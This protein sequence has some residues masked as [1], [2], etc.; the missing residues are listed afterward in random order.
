M[1]KHNKMILLTE[2]VPTLT[3]VG[4][5]RLNSIKKGG[6]EDEPDWE[7]LGIPNPNA[8]EQDKE[9]FVEL[10]EEDFEVELKD[11]IVDSEYIAY[12]TDTGEDSGSRIVLKSG[13]EIIVK[14]SVK[15]IYHRF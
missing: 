14:E 1:N 9:G 11:V 7:S 4:S 6:K 2:I 5:K 10:E 3:E 12:V 8:G 15:E 13:E